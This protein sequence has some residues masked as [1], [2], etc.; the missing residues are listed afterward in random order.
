MKMRNVALGTSR[1]NFCIYFISVNDF[2]ST[3]EGFLYITLVLINN[4]IS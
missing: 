2:I 1:I 3:N 4:N